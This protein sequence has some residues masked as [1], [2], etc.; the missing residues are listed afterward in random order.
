MLRVVQGKVLPQLEPLQFQEVGT[1][2]R[3]RLNTLRSFMQ[4]SG[5]YCMLTIS[6]PQ[7][8]WGKWS[9]IGTRHVHSYRLWLLLQPRHKAEQRHY[10][11][12]G[13]QSLKYLLSY[14]SQKKLATSVLA[15]CVNL[16]KMKL[17]SLIK[18]SFSFFFFFMLELY[19]LSYWLSFVDQ[20]SGWQFCKSLLIF[21]FKWENSLSPNKRN[22]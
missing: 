21:F 8:F 19:Q 10:R 15:E 14:L 17:H 4:G 12:H 16:L 22:L 1:R 5:N 18:M 11:P 20:R 7:H 9:L 6:D 3:K 13:L 2:V